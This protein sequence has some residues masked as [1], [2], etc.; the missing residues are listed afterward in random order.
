MLA[1]NLRNRLGE[2]DLVA[3]APDRKTIV[4]VEVKSTSADARDLQN[5]TPEVHVNRA[6]QRK[7]TA[8]ACQLC[9]QYGW[10]DRP[11]RFD[12]IGVEVPGPRSGGEP[13][14]RHHMAAFESQV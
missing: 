10:S 12:V 11:I 8:L 6:K 4:I 14:I 9:R 7:L 5:R 3:E 2:V 1:R 13:V